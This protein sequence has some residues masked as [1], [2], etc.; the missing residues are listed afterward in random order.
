MTTDL[1]RSRVN[2]LCHRPEDQTV[3]LCAFPAE[4]STK[5]AQE[6]PHAEQRHWLT[7][8]PVIKCVD[9]EGAVTT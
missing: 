3:S 6:L 5:V 4:E 2:D 7:I 1:S 8:F 9:P